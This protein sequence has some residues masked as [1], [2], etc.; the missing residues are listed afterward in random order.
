MIHANIG[1]INQHYGL[2]NYYKQYYD[3]IDCEHL[4]GIKGI[5]IFSVLYL[6][7]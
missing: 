3:G 2:N 1:N 5:L 4:L 6:A 7:G